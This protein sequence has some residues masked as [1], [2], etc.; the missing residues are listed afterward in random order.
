MACIWNQKIPLAPRVTTAHSPHQQIS[1]Y[2][3]HS[4]YELWNVIILYWP[5]IRSLQNFK[6]SGVLLAFSSGLVSSWLLFIYHEQWPPW[7]WRPNNSCGWQF[8][9]NKDKDKRLISQNTSMYH[10]LT[11]TFL[12]VPCLCMWITC[13]WIPDYDPHLFMPTFLFFCFCFVRCFSTSFLPNWM[14][15]WNS[16]NLSHH[17]LFASIVWIIDILCRGHKTCHWHGPR[18]LCGLLS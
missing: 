17:G 2:L 8:P 11:Y 6:F 5:A 9:H 4:V 18:G 3:L 13:S 16:L 15:K 7:S 14:V 1:N 12:R 10:V